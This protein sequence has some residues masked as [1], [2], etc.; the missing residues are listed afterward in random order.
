MKSTIVRILLLALVFLIRQQSILAEESQS[1]SFRFVDLFAG[2]GGIRFGFEVIGGQCVFT[3]EIDKF[4]R[5]TYLANFHN[6]PEHVF[7]QD[8]RSITRPEGFKPESPKLLK[9]I[10]QQIPDHDVLLA[11][12]P[13]QPFSIA[14]VSSRKYRGI[15]HGFMDE[16]QGTLFFDLAL[17]IRVK[18][19]AIFVL[20]NVRNLK[21]HDGGNTYRVIIETLESLGYVISDKEYQS[22][23]DP[24]IIDAAHFLPQHRERIVLV[25]FRKDL[26]LHQGFSLDD[27]S[28]FYPSER[29]ALA[30]LLD[31]NVPAKYTLTEKTWA[32]LNKHAERHREKDQGFGYGLVD[33]SESNVVTRTLT[34]RYHKD[35]SEILLKQAAIK[36][37]EKARPRKLTPREAARLMGFEKAGETSF[38]IP[39]SDTQAWKQFGNAVAVPVFSAVA[40]LL[41]P[42]IEQLKRQPVTTTALASEQ[43]VN[44]NNGLCISRSSVRE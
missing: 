35:G 43:P 13:C 4:A 2:I 40:R 22:R 12:F 6:S 26:N 25:G 28:R 14:G 8:I 24:K 33:P 36:D 41:Q 23:R 20:E 39:V 30:D 37:N 3:S 15:P 11:G 16:I 29:P 27:I 21:S 17:I 44:D 42:R 1:N 34:A 10:D 31:N 38:V 5:K 18:R 7:N 9:F 32:F 19:P